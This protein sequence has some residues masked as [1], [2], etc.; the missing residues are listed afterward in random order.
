MLIAVREPWLIEQMMPSFKVAMIALARFASARIGVSAILALAVWA[1]A[2]LP[3]NNS[4]DNASVVIKNRLNIGQ[5][6]C[7][8]KCGECSECPRSSRCHLVSWSPTM[9]LA[10]RSWRV[11]GSG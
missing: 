1:R 7:Q 11:T 9:T 4:K 10:N 3:V 2:I 8:R 6:E 5:P